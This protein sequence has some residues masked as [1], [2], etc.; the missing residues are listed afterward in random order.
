ML[1]AKFGDDPEEI[2]IGRPFV[3]ITEILIKVK[4]TTLFGVVEHLVFY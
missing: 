4:V 2:N 3:T 1:E